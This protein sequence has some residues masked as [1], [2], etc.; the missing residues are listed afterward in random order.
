MLA[1][2]I[3]SNIQHHSI[4]VGGCVTRERALELHNSLISGIGIGPQ[5]SGEDYNWLLENNHY[6]SRTEK[7]EYVTLI[8][9]FLR[10]NH[11]Q[12]VPDPITDKPYNEG[13]RIEHFLGVPRNPRSQIG[14]LYGLELKA[15][16]F[17]G[18]SP[19]RLKTLSLLTSARNRAIEADWSYETQIQ[20]Y[21]YYPQHHGELPR[22]Q[23]RRPPFIC[24]NGEVIYSEVPNKWGRFRFILD[25]EDLLRV[26]V[27]P[28]G[29]GKWLDI[30]RVWNMR[31]LLSKFN[32]G[33][34]L[35]FYKKRNPRLINLL[36]TEVMTELNTQRILDDIRNGIIGIEVR[37][38]NPSRPRNPGEVWQ[39]NRSMVW[40]LTLDSTHQNS[41]SVDWTCPS[42]L[43]E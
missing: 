10:V 6:I 27:R 20:S 3:E 26:A 22:P 41:R 17:S 4:V 40:Q 21:V 19:L 11:S 8:V 34:V 43:F 38:K 31:A 36:H 30:E 13:D 2:E 15:L 25:E 35:V 9:R 12:C 23:R 29:L 33:C 24:K 16:N 7:V 42:E 28:S 14:D 1:I 32:L 39:Y 5:I 37:M 18:S